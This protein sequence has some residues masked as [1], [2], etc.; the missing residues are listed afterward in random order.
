MLIYLKKTFQVSRTEHASVT[1]K[2]ELCPTK[3]RTKLKKSN[4]EC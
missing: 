3:A 4:R 2:D 1:N